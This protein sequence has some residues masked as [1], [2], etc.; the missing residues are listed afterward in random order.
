MSWLLAISRCST[1]VLVFHRRRR[2]TAT[3]A[4][5]RLIAVQRLGLGVTLVRDGHH[6]VFLIDEVFHGEVFLS[7]EDLGAAL[8]AVGLAHLAELFAEHGEQPLFRIED[9]LQIGDLVEDALVVLDQL[10][11][12]EG[13]QP[14]QAQL[15]DG[16][17][18]SF[19]QVVEAFAEAEL[20]AEIVRT[21]GVAA[22]ALQQLL[23]PF[24]GPAAAHQR[25]PGFGGG[26]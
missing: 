5:L 16:L 14:V 3:A 23:H 11:L 19:R 4:A 8:V 10:V 20:V 22:G 26:R 6:Q 12:L 9:V 13:G 24:S 2:P 17:S 1:K 25:F 15:E 21:T 18:L 7:G